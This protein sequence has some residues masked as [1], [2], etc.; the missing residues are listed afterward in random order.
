MAGGLWRAGGS[1]TEYGWA[2]WGWGKV[3]YGDVVSMGGQLWYEA[4]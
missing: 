4:C 2:A 1:R 3:P